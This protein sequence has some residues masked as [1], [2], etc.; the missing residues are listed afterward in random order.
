M[1]NKKYLT[2]SVMVVI[3]VLLTVSSGAYFYKN[4]KSISPT[5][6][7]PVACTMDAKMCPDGSYVGRTGVNCEF[8]CPE[9]KV[10]LNNELVNNIC[11][12]DSNCEYIWYTGG[13]NTPEYIA[14][15]YKEA[16]EKGMYL[17]EAPPRDNVTCT[18]EDSKCITH[19]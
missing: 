17:G 3:I 14:K 10:T 16:E 19:N 1:N 12:K 18:C 2:A 6:D 4:K 13:C 8:V 9:I 7:S 15:K 5:K 11:K